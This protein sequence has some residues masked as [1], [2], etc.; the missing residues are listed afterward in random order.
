[1]AQCST[2]APDFVGGSDRHWQVQFMDYRQ[3]GPQTV[4]A[5]TRLLHLLLLKAVGLAV[6][7]FP[8]S[9]LLQYWIEL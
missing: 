7:L 6:V 3:A 9:Q 2:V 5:A 1:L 8:A 4:D